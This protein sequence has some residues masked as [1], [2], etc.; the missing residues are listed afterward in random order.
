L[1]LT[2]RRREGNVGRLLVQCSILFGT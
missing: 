2:R 1:E